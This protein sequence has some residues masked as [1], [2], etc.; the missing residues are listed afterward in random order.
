MTS[1]AYKFLTGL[2]IATTL[3]MANFCPCAMASQATAAQGPKVMACCMNEVHGGKTPAGNHD[4]TSCMLCC[5]SRSSGATKPVQ[6]KAPS[7]QFSLFIFQPVLVHFNPATISEPNELRSF[8]TFIDSP[9]SLLRL[10]CA[11]LI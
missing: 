1:F 6:I 11:L 4:N 2:L 8:E 3:L 7:P 5:A 10:H 9:K